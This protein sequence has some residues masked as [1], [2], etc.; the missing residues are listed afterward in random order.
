[1]K[2]II[3]VSQNATFSIMLLAFSQIAVALSQYDLDYIE[4]VSSEAI[5]VCIEEY[6]EQ[7]QIAFPNKVD[8]AYVLAYHNEIG[9]KFTFGSD[10]S[11]GVSIDDN[12]QP[13][14]NCQLNESLDVIF[15]S[16]PSEGPLVSKQHVPTSIYKLYEKLVYKLMFLRNDKEFDFK[17]IEKDPAPL[18]LN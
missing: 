2:K 10:Y 4:Q 18:A 14:L 3:V 5:S 16:K 8:R 15:L 11:F 7:S 17:I 1:M 13:I 6:E 12:Y 9:V